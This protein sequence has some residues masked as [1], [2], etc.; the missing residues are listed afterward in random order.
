MKTQTGL[1][2]GGGVIV[3]AIAGY[4]IYSKSKNSTTATPST[5]GTGAATASTST[6]TSST[7]GVSSLMSLFTSSF[8][9]SAATRSSPFG[10]VKRYP[11][12]Y[13]TDAS[14]SYQLL[15]D[16]DDN[17]RAGDLI[18]LA[19][20]PDVFDDGTTEQW[21]DAGGIRYNSYGVTISLGS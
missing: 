18:T 9:D 11:S 19:L 13:D 4:V 17:H 15:S 14:M 2:I 20:I 16:Y 1:I 21:I 6:T 7:S 3:A 8:T 12:K 10:T 5:S